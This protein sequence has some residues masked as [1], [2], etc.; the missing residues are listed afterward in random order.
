MKELEIVKYT[1]DLR[2]YSMPEGA[3][4]FLRGLS[5]EEQMKYFRI[6]ETSDSPRFADYACTVTQSSNAKSLIVDE[7]IIVG[8]MIYDE[9]GS[10]CPCYIGERVCTFDS[11]DNNGAGYKS[12]TD[13]SKLI[14]VPEKN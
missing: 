8:V 12:R 10:L 6:L 5:I 9:Y 2:E 4:E 14:F 13:Y 1:K 7:D 3:A 11:S